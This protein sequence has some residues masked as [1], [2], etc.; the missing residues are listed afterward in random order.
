MTKSTKQL[1]S[2][3]AASLRDYDWDSFAE[4][5]AFAFWASPYMS[6]VENLSEDAREAERKYESKKAE[7]LRA[8]YDAL[9]P[10]P[11]GAWESVLPETPASARVLGKKFAKAVRE[12]LTAPELSAVFDKFSARDAG[13]YGAMQSQ[14]EGVGWFDEGVRADPPRGFQ[15]DPKIQNAVSRAIASEARRAGVRLPR[16]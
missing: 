1:D 10:G 16:R 8:A 3:I 13:Y 9:S 2:D 12:K 15:W 7:A 14:G 11:G 4:G 5:A 6:E